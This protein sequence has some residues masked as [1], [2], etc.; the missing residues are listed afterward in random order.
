VTPRLPRAAAL[1]G[2]LVAAVALAGPALAAEPARVC[3][4][5][6]PRLD[7][8][9]GM[10][11][12]PA[13]LAVVNDG[14]FGTSVLRIYVLNQACQVS[15]VVTDRGFDPLDPEDLARTP[16][17][18]FWVGDLGDNDRERATV[19]VDRISPG[20]GRG[21]TFR[22]TYP[23]GAHDAEALLMQRDGTAVV[24]TKELSGVARVFAS[25]RPLTGAAATV[26]LRDAG[27]VTVAATSTPGGPDI[28]GFASVLVTGGA[29]A[30]DGRR[31]LLRTYTDAYEWDVPDGDLARAL[32]SGSPRRT[33][34]PD[35]PQGEAITYTADGRGYLTLSE[36][37][38]EVVRR[39]TPAA[40]PP[41]ASTSAPAATAPAGEPSRAGG[42]AGS[43]WTGGP[44]ATVLQAAAVVGL[45]LL[46]FGVVAL[47]R[48]RRRARRRAAAPA[49]GPG[50]GRT[51]I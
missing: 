17:G 37:R 49:G 12:T 14:K 26:A 16:D 46:V 24:V 41:G 10:V 45:A 42:P 51:D 39:W 5:A 30:P 3:A 2:G 28:G 43:G 25:A 44:L 34:L 47:F 7:E 19:A 29:V 20:G 23:D 11:A 8:V 35:E 40:A 32:T 50:R 9:S 38:D 31:A 36:G 4:V 22:L 18:A 21:T 48:G 15:R 1:L 6:D 27:S 13:G 33:P